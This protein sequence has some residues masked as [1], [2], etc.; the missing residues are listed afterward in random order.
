[1]NTSA[2]HCLFL[3]QSTRVTDKW[4]DRQNYGSKDRASIALRGKT[5]AYHIQVVGSNKLKKLT[6]FGI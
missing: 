4:T 3:S 2:V 1:M 6:L 5:E